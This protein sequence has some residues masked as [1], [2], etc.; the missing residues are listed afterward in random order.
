MDIFETGFTIIVPVGLVLVMFGMGLSLSLDDFRRVFE[1]PKAALLGIVG[2]LLLLP[3]LA[4]ALTAV[5]DMPKDIAVALTLLN[6]KEMALT[7]SIY[8]ALMLITGGL[9]A[10]LMARRHPP[11]SLDGSK[12]VV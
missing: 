6:M 5:V 10:W 1:F 12:E 3:A 9:F 8:A 7:P 4:F 11:V 2:Q